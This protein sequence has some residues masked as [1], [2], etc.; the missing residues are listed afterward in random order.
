MDGN[1]T[2]FLAFDHHLLANRSFTYNIRRNGLHYQ[3]LFQHDA[4]RSAQYL[5]FQIHMLLTRELP[6]SEVRVSYNYM[7]KSTQI[8]T[9]N[10]IHCII[11]VNDWCFVYIYEN[12]SNVTH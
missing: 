7:R 11:F 6:I 9:I 3:P 8:V 5:Y 1:K 10:L 12:F 2:K 4:E